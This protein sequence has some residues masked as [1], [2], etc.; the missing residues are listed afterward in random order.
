MLPQSTSPVRTYASLLEPVSDI[1]P[2]HRGKYDEHEAYQA[3][4][5]HYPKEGERMVQTSSVL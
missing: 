5:S 4:S 1:L 2:E 3:G